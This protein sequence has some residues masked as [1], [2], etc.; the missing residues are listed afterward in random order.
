MRC[1]WMKLRWALPLLVLAWLPGAQALVIN[2]HFAVP[3]ERSTISPTGRFAPPGPLTGGGSVSAVFTAAA[4]NWESLL[5]D[6]RTFNITVGWASL[7]SGVIAAAASVNDRVNEIAI[8]TRLTNFADPTPGENE[9]FSGFTEDSADLG[10]GLI[11][12]GRSFASGDITGF[13]LLSTAMHEIGHVLGNILDGPVTGGTVYPIVGGP[14]DGTELPC[15]TTS[16]ICAH[17]NLPHAL[18]NPFDSAGERTLISGADLLYIAA[19][20]RFTDV[21]LSSVG[22]H[23][24]PEPPLPA[25]AVVALVALA[26]VRGRRSWRSPPP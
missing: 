8:S 1:A 10:G 3:G 2:F 18:M 6:N 9:E 4:L 20:G 11:N 16:G 21:D 23:D 22:A 7:P 24:A 25:L 17:L 5:L 15:A 13:D 12:I 26:A 14:F 19:D